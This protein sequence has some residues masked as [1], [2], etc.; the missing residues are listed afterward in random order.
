MEISK[1][2]YLTSDQFDQVND[3]WNAEFPTTLNNRFS[4]LLENV[5]NYN[6][7]IIEE[8]GK[9]LAWAAD[10]EKEGQLRFSII[11]KNDQQGK[12]FG[13]ILINRLKRDLGEFFGWV[14]D[15]DDYSRQ[16]GEIYRSPLAFYQKNGFDVLADIRSD[17][18][19]IKAV[20]IR[21]SPKIF[22]ETERF[23]LREILPSDVDGMFELDSDQ[24]VHQYLGNNPF[25]KKEQSS[26]TI[27]FIRQQYLDYGIG[28]WAIIEK[29]T[30]NFVGW[31]GL[32]FISDLTNNHQNYYDLGYRIIKKYWGKGIATETAIASL[33]YAFENLNTNEVYAIADSRNKNSQ[34]ILKKVG[35][36][37]LET[38]KL[39]GFPHEWFKITKDKYS[40][41]TTKK[42]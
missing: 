26:D 6:H 9:V 11:V 34:N 33:Q 30:N 42:Q 22:A 17:S 28:R 7:Y 21:N 32:K 18:D 19:L 39:D 23:I 14:I 2:K 1:I 29:V 5:A 24:D 35:L 13:K 3:M 12:G 8:N 38:F 27:L 4:L 10:F 20:K 16:N 36:C 25:T 31:T 40:N 15:C 37:H 41:V